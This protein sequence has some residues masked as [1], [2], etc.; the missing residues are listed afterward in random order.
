MLDVPLCKTTGGPEPP[1]Y[2]V[3]IGTP[4]IEV[5]KTKLLKN[6]KRPSNSAGL[7]PIRSTPRWGFEFVEKS[8]ERSLYPASQ[9]LRKNRFD[10]KDIS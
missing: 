2:Q 5:L 4:F 7:P 8:S 9:H 6:K 10:F 3:A 1:K